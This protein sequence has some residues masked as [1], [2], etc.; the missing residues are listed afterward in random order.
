MKSFLGICNWYSIYDPNHASVA[1]PLNNSFAGKYKYD[2]DKGTSKVQ[3]HKQ[4]ISCTDLMRENL[5][6]I[7]ISLCEACSLYIPSDQGEC[8]FH[9]DSSDHGIGAVPEQNY[10]Q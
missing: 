10:N 9:T 7:K 2:P 5:K 1:A 4:A 3:A 6:K 8:P